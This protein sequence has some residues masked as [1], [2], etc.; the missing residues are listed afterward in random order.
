MFRWL[1]G[2]GNESPK[3][4]AAGILINGRNLNRKHNG[5]MNIPEPH[6][7]G[8]IVAPGMRFKNIYPQVIQKIGDTPACLQEEPLKPFLANFTVRILVIFSLATIVH[9]SNWTFHF[10]I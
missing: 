3:G 4:T 2:S 5:R 6:V 1:S 7:P 8:P 10:N 9:S